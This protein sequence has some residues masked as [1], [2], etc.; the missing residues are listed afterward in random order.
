M[1]PWSIFRMKN[2][3]KWPYVYLETVIDLNKRAACNALIKPYRNHPLRDILRLSLNHV[4]F[5][6][7]PEHLHFRVPTPRGEYSCLRALLMLFW[8]LLRVA[9]YMLCTYL[10]CHVYILGIYKTINIFSRPPAMTK[11]RPPITKGVTDWEF[12]QNRIAGWRRQQRQQ[13][14]EHTDP[15]THHARVVCDSPSHSGLC[16]SRATAFRALFFKHIHQL[17]HSH[18]SLSARLAV[19]PF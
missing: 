5:D 11:G 12:G 14:Q 8:G 17:L 16:C 19:L 9:E 15:C 4:E 13:Q 7:G 6:N 10:L 2:L 1:A 3:L 18:Y